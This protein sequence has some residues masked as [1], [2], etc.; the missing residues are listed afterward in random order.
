MLLLLLYWLWLYCIELLLY[1]EVCWLLN[2]VLFLMLWC[3]LGPVFRVVAVCCNILV[4][5]A[6][7]YWQLYAVCCCC[8]LWYDG[9]CV[10]CVVVVCCSM[11]AAVCGVLLLYAV[12]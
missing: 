11:M 1:V 2:V 10:W 12:V 8:M 6:V 4:A 9:C 7:V 3:I 5:V